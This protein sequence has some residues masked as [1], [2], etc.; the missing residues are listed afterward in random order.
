MKKKVF[1]VI[2]KTKFMLLLSL[3]SLNA[4]ANLNQSG[5][6]KASANFKISVRMAKK[7]RVIEENSTQVTASNSTSNMA[8]TIPND[9]DEDLNVVIQ[10]SGDNED[11]ILIS[12]DHDHCFST[13]SEH[14]NLQ[15][16]GHDLDLNLEFD[17]HQASEETN[18]YEI[19]VLEE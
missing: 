17:S 9:E 11:N 6:Y 14:C 8:V 12:D 1:K 3:T 18:S 4:H 16:A 2:V 15:I 13:D 19:L 5:K 10:R 7:N